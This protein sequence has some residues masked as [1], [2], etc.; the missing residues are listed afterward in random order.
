MA[1]TGSKSGSFNGEYPQYATPYIFWSYEQ[2]IPN[3]H[4]I[5]TATLKVKREKTGSTTNKSSTPWSITIGGST[6]SGTMSFKITSVSAGEYITI[7]TASKTISHNGDGS[8]SA[9]AISASINISGTTLG[10]GSVSTSVTPNTIPRTSSIASIVG[11]ML[12]GSVT[13]N[14]DRKSDSFVH[15]VFYTRFD[16]AVYTVG[17]SVGT[18][19][20]FT[21]ALGDASYIPNSTSGTATITVDTYSNGTKIGSV[22]QAITLYVPDSVVPSISSISVTEGGSVV[23]SSWGIYVQGKS[24]LKVVTSASGSYG[25]SITGYKITGIDN[26]TYY[27]SNFTSAVLQISGSRTITVTVTDSRGRTA[28]KTTT[29]ECI[30]YFNPYISL[31]KVDRCNAD[32]TLNDEGLY[33]KYSFEGGL[34]NLLGKNTQAFKIGYRVTGSGSNYTYKNVSINVS[35]VVLAGVTFDVNTSYDIQFYIA[36]YFTSS[37]KVE[38]LSSGFSL[39][40]YNASGKGMAI[41]KISEKDAFEVGI[42]MYYKGQLMLEYEV[43]DEW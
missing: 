35:N 43:V 15:N 4:T 14:I 37:A 40:D 18:S 7:G 26:S 6:T 3:N 19:C 25:S 2:S 16:G 20:S 13:V 29:Y 28:T 22:S 9:I 23:P 39:T 17:S 33:L 1:I 31:S 10:T 27:S 34:A 30:A 36:D 11:N 5:L 24:S 38:P 41:G 32:G 12:G 21:P 8:C 42:P